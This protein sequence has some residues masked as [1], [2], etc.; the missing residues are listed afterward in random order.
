MLK[1]KK[2]YNCKYEKLQ[3]LGEGAYGVV[4]KVAVTGIV[5]KLS[6]G[7]TKRRISKEV[8]CVKKVLLRSCI[9]K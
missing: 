7:R 2:I 4:Y 3:K 8:L 5:N 6:R 9:T 1:K